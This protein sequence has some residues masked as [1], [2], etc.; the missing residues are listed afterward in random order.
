ME[1]HYNGL[2]A[3][4]GNY[5]DDLVGVEAYE[6]GELYLLGQFYLGVS[7]SYQIT[8]LLTAQMAAIL[9]VTDPSLILSPT[10]TYSLSQDLDLS[11]GSFVGVGESP[12]IVATGLSVPSEFGAA[13]AF[14]YLQLV[15][16]Y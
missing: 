8:E 10:L 15:A 6:R 13:N 7:G 11:I 1:L 14:T 12:S 5:L 2:G 3:S 16:Y 9:N 4:P